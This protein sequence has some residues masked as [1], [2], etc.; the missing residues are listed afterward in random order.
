[1]SWLLDTNVVS[2]L[3]KPRP[4][5]NVVDWINRR[6]RQQ[7]HLYLSALTLAELY[8]GIMRGDPQAPRFA[9]LWSWVRS[10]VTTR[11]AGRILPFD[12]DVAQTWGQMMA[13]LPKG[14][15]APTMDSLIAATAKHYGLILV[16]R[17]V[18]DVRHFPGLAADNPWLT[19]P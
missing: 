5:A 17:N 12:A 2:E 11:F 18:V 15:V 8:R 9:R 16:T 4:D 7:A 3:A 6:S 10:D 1:V 13:A 14:V 19:G